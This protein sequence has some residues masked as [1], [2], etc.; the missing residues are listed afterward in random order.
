MRINELFDSK[1]PYQWLHQGTFEWNGSFTLS[2]SSVIR[3]DMSEGTNGY[4]DVLFDRTGNGVQAS[5]EDTG[6]GDS[7]KVF[8]T[9]VAMIKEFDS[10]KIPT[11]YKFLGYKSDK[12]SARDSRV[13]LYRTLTA[14]FKGIFVTKEYDRGYRVNFKMTR[15]PQVTE[16]ASA[17]ATASGSV[18]SSVGG[19]GAGFSDDY[20]K[21]IYG[22]PVVIRRNPR[23]KKRK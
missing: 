22:E 16:T 20:S 15:I 23:P 11:G 6:Q 3:L 7:L 1:Y 18:A 12:P 13:Q 10:N 14:K 5:V 4:W 2:D 8:G 21:S 17:G 9:I 19:L